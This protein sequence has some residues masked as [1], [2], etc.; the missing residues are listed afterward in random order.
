MVNNVTFSAQLYLDHCNGN[1]YLS[2]KPEAV[3]FRQL[4]QAFPEVPS[5]SDDACAHGA[6]AAAQCVRLQ[7]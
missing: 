3:F 4:V 7:T 1:S 5:P 6:A 2:K